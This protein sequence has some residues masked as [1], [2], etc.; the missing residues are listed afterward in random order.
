MKVG[1]SASVLGSTIEASELGFD[2]VV[3]YGM[4]RVARGSQAATGVAWTV[5][6]L[7]FRP[8]AVFIGSKTAVARNGFVID[9]VNNNEAGAKMNTPSLITS[10][11]IDITA[12][13]F[14]VADADFIVNAQ[15]YYWVAFG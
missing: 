8:V 6:G 2:P 13:G 7:S 4:A 9:G 14:T 15:T 11:S 3:E 12:D 10:T 1:R 5:A